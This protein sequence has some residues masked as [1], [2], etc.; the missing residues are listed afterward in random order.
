MLS[1]E[2]SA[3]PAYAQI[4][5]LK[6]FTSYTLECAR[7]SWDLCV[8]SPPMLLSCQETEFCLE[9][10]THFYDSN[11]TSPDIVL[12]LWPTLIQASGHTLVRGIVMT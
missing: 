2:H 8:Q 11:K 12:H 9:M 10:H 7:L 3:K 1:E 5:Q 4:R 6:Q